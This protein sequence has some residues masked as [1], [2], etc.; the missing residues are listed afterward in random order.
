[1]Q[2]RAGRTAGRPH[3][4]DQLAARHARAIGDEE[5]QRAQAAGLGDDRT[6]VMRRL[7]EEVSFEVTEK[8]NVMTVSLVGGGADSHSLGAE[9]ET[10]YA[11][12]LAATAEA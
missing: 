10:R 9:F 12:T 1:M 3:Q 7:D 2:V 6:P 11:K 8:D 4:C 5:Q